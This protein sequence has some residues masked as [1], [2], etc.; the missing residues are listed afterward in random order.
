MK[1]HVSA[2]MENMSGYRINHP[3]PDYDMAGLYYSLY[4]PVGPG[5]PVQT[6]HDR[7]RLEDAVNKAIRFLDLL[8]EPSDEMSTGLVPLAKTQIFGVLGGHF[9][10]PCSDAGCRY[11]Q[12]TGGFSP[13]FVVARLA[14]LA[15]ID[16]ALPLEELEDLSFE[17]LVAHRIVLQVIQIDWSALQFENA[18][19][20][21]TR[22]GRLF[23]CQCHEWSLRISC[24]F[25]G[26]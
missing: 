15:E 17:H 12:Y 8:G 26:C 4:R 20:C 9:Q 23:Q 22:A 13:S 25:L 3:T 2:D 7:M 18:L 14:Q 1:H 10:P 11:P 21:H 16:P 19:F 6:F 5:V 24:Y